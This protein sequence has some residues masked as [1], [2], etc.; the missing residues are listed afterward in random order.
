[1]G[2]TFHI[3]TV[4]LSPYLEDSS[5]STGEQVVEEIRSACTTSGFFQIIGHGVSRELQ[6]HVFDAAKAVFDL[7]VEEKLKLSGV[8]GRGYEAIGTQVLE[9][10]KPTD[11]KEV[12]CCF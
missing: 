1:M 7:P 12:R 2:K 11:L 5:S 6:G 10:G 9:A 4:D 8:P 3:P